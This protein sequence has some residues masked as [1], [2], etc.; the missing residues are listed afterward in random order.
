[1]KEV[2]Y[3]IVMLIAKIHDSILQINDAFEASFSDKE[4]HFFVIGLLGLLIFGIVH[5]VFRALARRKLVGIISWIYAFTVIL[6]IAFAIE[7]GQY[8]TGTG[9]MEFADIASGLAG[10]LFLSCLAALLC[11]I[12]SLIRNLF[13]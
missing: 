9:S 12:L 3:R 1:M 6:V 2:L 13:H 5:P 4:L 7:I 10:F 8:F 11:S